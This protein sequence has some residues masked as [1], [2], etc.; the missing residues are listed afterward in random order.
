MKYV[1]VRTRKGT[2][3]R[4][5]PFS[6]NTSQIKGK[7]TVSRKIYVPARRLS[8]PLYRVPYGGFGLTK[9]VRLKYCDQY[10]I[11]ALAG[12]MASHE[13]RAN[14]I[15]DPDFSGGGHQP[16][17]RDVYAGIYNKYRVLSSKITVK[18]V[19]FPDESHCI[20]LYLDDQTG[21][22]ATLSAVREQNMAKSEAIVQPQGKNN[23]LSLTYSAK[24]VFGKDNDDETLASMGTNPANQQMFSIAAQNLN[25]SVGTN[26]QLVVQIE[27]W[28]QLSDLKEQVQN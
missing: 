27:Y 19:P 7:R 11:T 24:K 5:V 14:S 12:S 15:F 10:L 8:T 3:L 25:N 20:V 4:R 17:F 13:W 28:V 26:C 18:A 2:L 6:F 9:V 22:P 23:I 21:L 16:M 1:D